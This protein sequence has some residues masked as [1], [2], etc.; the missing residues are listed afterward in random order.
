MLS[1]R[2]KSSLVKVST[3]NLARVL[4]LALGLLS[5]INIV[6]HDFSCH[7]ELH[8]V[9]SP[10]HHNFNHPD[11]SSRELGGIN[12]TEGFSIKPDPLFITASDFVPTIFHPPD[13]A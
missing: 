5:L 2:L 6:A 12:L 9:S 10:I 7:E 13:R 11:F 4:F 8:Q 1:D 3:I